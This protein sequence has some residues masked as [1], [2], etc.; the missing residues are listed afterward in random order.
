[1]HHERQEELA[2]HGESQRIVKI[3]IRGNIDKGMVNPYF[4]L[5]KHKELHLEEV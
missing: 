3:L 4:Q 5:E 2:G 1:M